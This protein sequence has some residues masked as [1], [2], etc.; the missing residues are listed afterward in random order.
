[1]S[2]QDIEASAGL[3]PSPRASA[4]TN[5]QETAF[6]ELQ[7]SLSLQVFKVTANTE[8]IRNLV[9]QLGT[10]RDS[11]V[12][13]KSLHELTET[14]RA[15]AKRASDDLKRLAALQKSLPNKRTALQ[16]TS[17]D[18]ERALVELQRAQKISVEKQRTVVQGVK[19]A[20]ADDEPPQSYSDT[21][22]ASSTA[23]QRQAQLFQQQLSPHELA[24]RT[25]QNGM[26][27]HIESNISSV[28]ADVS[29]G[30]DELHTAA[31][32][33]RRAAKRAACLMI[34]LVV[35]TAVVLLAILS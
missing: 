13:R 21:E 6:V 3:Q 24:S 22:A 11:A 8:G 20:I 25:Q 34:I 1:M 4:P 14:T 35:V 12:L 15:M 28:A 5:A 30:A 16:K 18:L 33:Q 31:Q 27:D 29:S 32:Y 17:N 2:F 9:E 19:L 10:G 7:S 23:A 26:I